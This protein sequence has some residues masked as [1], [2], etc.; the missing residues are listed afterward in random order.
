[1]CLVPRRTEVAKIWI[2]LVGNKL[3]K[4][5][6]LPKTSLLRYQELVVSSQTE[7][8]NTSTILDEVIIRF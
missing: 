6:W 4:L 2:M 8:S 1:M 3:G 5:L 7:F